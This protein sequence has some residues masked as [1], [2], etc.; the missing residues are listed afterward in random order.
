M[1]R[2]KY[3]DSEQSFLKVLE[4]SPKNQRTHYYL[5]RLYMKMKDYARAEY[6]IWKYLKIRFKH[7]SQGLWIPV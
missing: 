2:K 4:V 7:H 1:Y 6:A 5:A 3:P